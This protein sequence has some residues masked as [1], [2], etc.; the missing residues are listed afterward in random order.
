MVGEITN[1]KDAVGER[2]LHGDDPRDDEREEE[3]GG[4][5]AAKIGR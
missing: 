2:W 1:M 5:R 4:G 3:E